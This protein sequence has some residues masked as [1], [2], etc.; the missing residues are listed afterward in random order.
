MG[1]RGSEAAAQP[2]GSGNVPRSAMAAC[3]GLEPPDRACARLAGDCPQRGGPGGCHLGA[4]EDGQHWAGRV[5]ENLAEVLELLGDEEARDLNVVALAHHGAVKGT[6]YR[7]Q[8][9]RVLGHCR[10]CWIERAN[11]PVRAMGSAEGV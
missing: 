6:G 7:C 11:A 10:A 2:Q 5:V 9:I 4:A 3:G 8:R 1:T